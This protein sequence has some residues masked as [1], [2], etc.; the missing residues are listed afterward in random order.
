MYRIKEN[1]NSKLRETDKNG[2]I[3]FLIK[4]IFCYLG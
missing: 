4:F 1:M 2:D 3:N